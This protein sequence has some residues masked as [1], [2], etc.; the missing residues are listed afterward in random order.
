[1]NLYIISQ[2]E[3]SNMRNVLVKTFDPD[4]LQT[5][6]NTPPNIL[7]KIFNYSTIDYLCPPKKKFLSSIKA[8]RNNDVNFTIGNMYITVGHKIKPFVAYDNINAF[9]SSKTKD[10]LIYCISPIDNKLKFSYKNNDN[11]IIMADPEIFNLFFKYIY[12]KD[13]KI[14][15]ISP[16]DKEIIIQYFD[17]DTQDLEN[18]LLYAKA[19][20]DFWFNSKT[21]LIYNTFHKEHE[22]FHFKN[23]TTEKLQHSKK[24]KI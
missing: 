6:T 3:Q 5:L 13:E 21:D 7:K 20:L 17:N 19:R 24:L 2:R 12:T 10:D 4:V 16:S 11:N 18:Y 23:I 1:M 9:I 15:E 22:L 14:K 8:D